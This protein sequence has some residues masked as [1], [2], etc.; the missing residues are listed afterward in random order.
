MMKGTK[1]SEESLQKMSSS[2]RHKKTNKNTKNNHKLTREEHVKG[3][4]NA[5]ASN[6]LHKL[7]EGTMLDYLR[8][9][10]TQPGENNRALYEEF[11]DNFLKDAVA[12]PN[13]QA[14]RMLG[15]GLFNEN[16]LAKLDAET[17][18]LMARDVEFHRFRIRETLFDKQQAL[19]DN[20]T[21]R[22]MMVICSRRSGKTEFNARKIVD[23]ALVPNT[24]IAYYNL[25]FSNAIAQMYDRVMEVANKVDMGT[26]S[27]TSKSDGFIKFNNGSTVKFFGNSNNAE[28]DKARG[29]SYRLVIIDEV[30]AERNLKYLIN[31]VLSP[32]LKDYA[33]SQIIYTGTPP[34]NKVH[35]SHTLWNMPGVKKYHWTLLDNP[36]IPNR[37]TLIQDECKKRGISEDDPFIKR[38]YFGD[39]E[40]FDTETQVFK[41][42]KT[43]NQL[44]SDIIPTNI[45][46][47]VD[48]GFSDFNGVVAL[49]AD[50]NKRKA[51]VF[52][53]EKKFNKSSVS[54]IAKAITDTREE[55]LKWALS[56]NPKFELNKLQ[57]ITDT[58][59]K[60]ISYELVTTYGIKNVFTAYK[61]DK[62]EAI[63]QLSEWLRNGTI[64]IPENGECANECENTMY[65]RDDNDNILADIDDDLFHP[66]IMDALLYVSRQYAFDVMKASSASLG[67]AKKL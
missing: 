59:E 47:G 39:M 30:G 5:H 31:D 65:K 27:G 24:P 36:Y 34:R 28:A 14:A 25:T 42:Y 16:T 9:A 20:R 17:N 55:V 32:L 33:D 41:D 26:M 21:D 57:V 44:P 37:E 43:Y 66:D 56:K 3:A 35:Y 58:N 48:F 53:N 8:G 7:V 6:N 12:N 23:A 40:A 46:I 50:A 60:S 54:D 2:Q 19:F 62:Q 52:N 67:Q 13:G 4:L 61:Y 63:S 10:L 51:F 29:F 15:S 1:H 18:K 49:V 64:T 38:E 45:Y 11:V 22:E